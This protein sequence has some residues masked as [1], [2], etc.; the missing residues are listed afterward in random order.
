M[1]NG[2]INNRRHD[3]ATSKIIKEH[4]EMLAMLKR[5]LEIFV[6]YEDTPIAEIVDSWTDTGNLIME[7]ENPPKPPKR[8][9]LSKREP[10]LPNKHTDQDMTLP[11]W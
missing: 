4:G 7:V 8:P 9:I 1:E 11:A 3:P 2:Y 5:L 10:Y 6:Q